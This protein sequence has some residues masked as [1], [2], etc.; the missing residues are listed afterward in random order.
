[1]SSERKA[2]MVV[3]KSKS[4]K[5]VKDLGVRK[6]ASSQ[7][8]RVRGGIGSSSSGAGSGKSRKGWI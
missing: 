4:T 7:A 5:K 6:V 2:V 8:K 3:K 1:M